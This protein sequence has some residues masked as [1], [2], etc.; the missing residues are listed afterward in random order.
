MD[1]SSA[2]SQVYGR[3]NLPLA[4]GKVPHYSLYNEVAHDFQGVSDAL[5]QQVLMPNPFI[6]PR[7]ATEQ[8][9]DLAHPQFSNCTVP[10]V[11]FLSYMLVL[12]SRG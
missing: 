10:V 5:E 6:R 7:T 2:L 4:G 11:F 12:G 1:S 9:P 8:S 3:E